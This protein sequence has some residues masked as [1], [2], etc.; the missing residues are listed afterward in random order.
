MKKPENN[1]DRRVKGKIVGKKQCKSELVVNVISQ[2]KNCSMT[3]IFSK[4]RLNHVNILEY[5]AEI[6]KLFTVESHLTLSAMGSSL[7]VRFQTFLL[8]QQ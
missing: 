5:P 4:T 1:R 7:D 8:V 3:E 2:N 6:H